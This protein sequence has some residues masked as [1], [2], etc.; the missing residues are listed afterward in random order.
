MTLICPLEEL[1]EDFAIGTH[2]NDSS[3]LV[4][5]RK[6]VKQTLRRFGL[7]KSRR[8]FISAAAATQYRQQLAEI[9]QRDFRLAM[10]PLQSDPGFLPP[11]DLVD[12]VQGSNTADAN[13]FFGAS[14]RDMAFL[15]EVLR[16]HGFDLPRMERMLDFGVGMGRMLAQFLP[17]PLQLYGVDVNPV[18]V[19][20]TK[21]KLAG[22]ATIE[23]SRL[24]P[25]LSFANGFFDLLMANS[26]FTHMPYDAMPGWIAELARVMKPGGCVL[27]TIHDFSK[28]PAERQSAGWYERGKARGLHL[29][30]YLSP[31]RLTA[32][33][34]PAFELLEI[35]RFPPRQAY[36]VARRR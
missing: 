18:A 30:T 3:V 9:L 24:E 36:V 10:H 31:E 23:L 28:L 21:K 4:Q 16:T 19:E 33:W 20:W 2:S 32:L 29:N 17:F 25:P 7:L 11:R 35:R 12:Q 8:K 5:S 27:F 34:E 22:L 14:Y 13:T 15:L 6:A 1:S 26:V